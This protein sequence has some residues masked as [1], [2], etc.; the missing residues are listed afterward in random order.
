VKTKGRHF[1]TLV[2]TKTLDKTQMHRQQKQTDKWD[3]IELRSFSTTPKGTIKRVKIQPEE[4]ERTFA[5]YSPGKAVITK[6]I[7]N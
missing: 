4:Q 1:R 7:R 3:S 2:Q 6:Y 5:S